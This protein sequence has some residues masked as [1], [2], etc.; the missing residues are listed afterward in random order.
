MGNWIST[1]EIT[2]KKKPQCGK[3]VKTFPVP[4]NPYLM[5]ITFKHEH[6]KEVTRNVSP[7]ISKKQIWVC[8]YS[9]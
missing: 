9:A 8:R 6:Q 5:V 3:Y 2:K 4:L 1:Y 7:N